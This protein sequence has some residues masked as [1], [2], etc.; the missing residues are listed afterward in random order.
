MLFNIPIKLRFALMAFL[1]VVGVVLLFVPHGA[2]WSWLFLVPFVVL[3]VGYVLF[4]SLNSTGLALN[5]GNIDEAERLLSYTNP[6]WLFSFNRSTY[7]YLRGSIAMMKKDLNTCEA[8]FEKAL[9]L[10][11][12][13]DDQTAMVYLNLAYIHYQKGRIPQCQKCVEEIKKLK[14]NQP[15]IKEK[16]KEIEQAIKMQPDMKAAQRAQM[17]YGNVQNMRQMRR[18]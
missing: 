8:D 1:L 6:K 3:L 13:M 14:V 17:M 9:E 11:L 15:L 5:A 10:G 18:R 16:V 12:P 4:G 2:V 7:Y